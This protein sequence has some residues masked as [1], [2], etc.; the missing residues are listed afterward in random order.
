ML[1][2]RADGGREVPTG[3]TAADDDA[4]RVDA[5]F[6]GILVRPS[7]GGECVR[8]AVGYG[9][10]VPATDTILHRNGDESQLREWFGEGVELLRGS[11]RPAAAEV[12]QDGRVRWFTRPGLEHVGTQRNALDRGVVDQ[13]RTLQG[14]FILAE[15]FCRNNGLGPIL[16]FP[17]RMR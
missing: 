3:R 8:H 14:E 10:V 12:E 5:Q 17:A 16:D 7:E 2:N 11:T 4:F 1:G 9:A 13:G 15:K 6:V